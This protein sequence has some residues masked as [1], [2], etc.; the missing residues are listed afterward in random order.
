MG[1]S[2]NRHGRY[3][4]SIYRREGESSLIRREKSG[5]L[6]NANGLFAPSEVAH[7]LH[8]RR[9]SSRVRPAF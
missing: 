4:A 7:E 3:M 6:L 1:N 5:A 2:S 8:N 9:E